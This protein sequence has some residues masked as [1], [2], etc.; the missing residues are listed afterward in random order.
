MPKNQSHNELLILLSST[1]Y[2]CELFKVTLS[3]QRRRWRHFVWQRWLE[4]LE[5]QR[6]FSDVR[7]IGDAFDL[8]CLI[9]KT[10]SPTVQTANAFPN[11]RYLRRISCWLRRRSQVMNVHWRD[12]SHVRLFVLTWFQI[13]RF[14]RTSLHMRH[15]QIWSPGVF[16]PR[17]A[18]ALA[19]A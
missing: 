8:I 18:A 19:C 3:R 9:R 16:Q 6:L 5:I 15:R 7:N 4:Q 2:V 12:R 10:Y 14:V 13:K 17:R 11:W 1:R